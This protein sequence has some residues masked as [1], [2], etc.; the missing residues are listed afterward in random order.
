MGVLIF[1]GYI[2]LFL[3]PVNIILLFTFILSGQNLITLSWVLYGWSSPKSEDEIKAPK[4]YFAPNLSFTLLIP[5][6]NE[7]RVIKET[8][9]CIDAIN[10]PK[11]LYEPLVLC[12]VDD[13]NTIMAVKEYIKNNNETKVRLITF[14]CPTT[15]KPVALNIGLSIAKGKVIGVFDAEDEPSNEILNIVNTIMIKE[16]MDVVQSGVQLMDHNSHWFSLFNV[17]EYYFW[18]KSGLHFFNK[19]GNVAPL[20]GNTVFVKKDFL[21]KVGGWDENCLTEDADIGIRLRLINAKTRIAYDDRFLTKEETPSSVK[22]FVKQRTRWMQGFIQIFFKSDW[23]DLP[24]FRQ[25]FLSVYILLS[26]MIQVLLLLYIPLGIYISQ[27]FVLPLYIS[28]LSYM[29]FYLMAIQLTIYLIGFYKF[30]KAHN[31]EFSIFV[32]LKMIF[33]YYPYQILLAYSSIRALTRFVFGIK[34]WEKTKHINAHRAYET[35]Y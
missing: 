26:P 17:L 6:R 30:T 31:K 18:F 16:S 34:G 2:N 25:K 21:D 10:Y 7:A 8:L 9:K 19:I 5:A 33:Y 32:I 11:D 12:K 27:E 1:T 23:V 22:S 29:P 35:N 13:T 4:E 15:N 14:D 24:E 3:D 20:G 28:L